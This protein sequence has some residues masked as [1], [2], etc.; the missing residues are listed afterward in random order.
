M[1]AANPSMR[2]MNARHLRTLDAGPSLLSPT[3][4]RRPGRWR[5]LDQ[6]IS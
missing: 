2:D 1:A 6:V 4:L 5:P 3:A